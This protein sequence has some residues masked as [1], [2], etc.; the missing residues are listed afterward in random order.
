MAEPDYGYYTDIRSP[1][2]PSAG[3]I[4]GV[5]LHEHKDTHNS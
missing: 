3:L 5:Q 1:A 4:F 2:L